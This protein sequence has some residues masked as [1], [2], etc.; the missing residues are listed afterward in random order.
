[1]AANIQATIDGLGIQYIFTDDKALLLECKRV[2]K[3]IETYL[4]K[5]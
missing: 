5:R 2:I 3:M 4:C 1:M